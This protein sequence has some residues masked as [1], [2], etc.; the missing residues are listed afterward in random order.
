MYS[1]GQMRQAEETFL[2]TVKRYSMIKEGSTIGVGVS[3][4]VDSMVLLNLL[5][6]IR[7][8]F[9]LKVVVAH[10][11]HNLRGKGSEEDYIFVCE[12]AESIGL[13]FYGATL[14]EPETEGLEGE[15]LQ[16]YLRSMRYDFFTRIMESKGLD[17]LATGHNMDDLA[18]TV[19]MRLMKGTSLKGLGS[20][21]PK[22]GPYIRPLIELARDQIL[23][24]AQ[25]NS[26][27]YREDPTNLDDKYLRNSVRL[28]LLPLIKRLYNESVSAS[29][30][31]T[32]RLLREDEDFI[33][34]G[35]E[36]A[37]KGVVVEEG[38]GT[39]TLDKGSLT[40]LHNSILRRIL[41]DSFSKVSPPSDD[42]I[43]SS[44]VEGIIALIRSDN[45]SA[46]ADLPGGLTAR[47]EYGRLIISRDNRGE[48]TLSSKVA[49]HVDLPIKVPGTTEVPDLKV[50]IRTTL[51]EALPSLDDITSEGGKEV[52]YLD[53]ERVGMEVSLRTIKEGDRIRPRGMEG[54]KRVSRI[55][56][57][58][59][60]PRL[61]RK[62]VP[63]LYRDGEIIW[64]CGIRE[65]G[66]FTA[67]PES[68]RVLK[69]EYIKG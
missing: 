62:E 56:I 5:L 1:V 45:P 40:T 48:P 41:F 55:L 17:N 4:G 58:E 33:S 42:E 64:L 16:A 7:E 44:H 30:S 68:K 46:S 38:E 19:L 53:L 12:Y 35:V 8:R 57:D 23:E 15:S 29:I 63:V 43:T 26:I 51:I 21:P 61:M 39:V 59:K 54:H 37:L 24:Y 13:E 34:S 3:G 36:E 6:S 20:I 9:S 2:D 69:V 11:N 10:L 65:S 14:R 32:A 22:R 66:D 49:F 47:R 50:S 28:N 27:P 67:T 31:R 60:V 52:V 25:K 18:E